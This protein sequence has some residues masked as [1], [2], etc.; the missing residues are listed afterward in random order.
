MSTAKER[1][2]RFEL[3]VYKRALE[4]LMFNYYQAISRA[5]RVNYSII[6]ANIDLYLKRAKTQLEAERGQ[7]GW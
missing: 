3:A 2:L 7:A 4:I 5:K 1:E 6:N